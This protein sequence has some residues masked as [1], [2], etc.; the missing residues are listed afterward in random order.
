MLFSPSLSNVLPN[1]PQPLEVATRDVTP[2]SSTPSSTTWQVVYLFSTSWTFLCSLCL[3][4]LRVWSMDYPIM[5]RCHCGLAAAGAS[6]IVGFYFQTVKRPPFSSEAQRLVFEDVHASTTVHDIL[7]TLRRRHVI[8]D[9]RRVANYLHYDTYRSSPLEL[10]N[11]CFGW[12]QA[13]GLGYSIPKLLPR[14]FA[15]RSSG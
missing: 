14:A 1:Q 15:A 6:E 2:Y 12:G 7:V 4:F 5:V 11:A 3:L 8:P 9:L 13:S 10:S